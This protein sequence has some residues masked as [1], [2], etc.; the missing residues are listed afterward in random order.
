MVYKSLA[1]VAIIL[2]SVHATAGDVLHEEVTRWS[3]NWEWQDVG[4]TFQHTADLVAEGEIGYHM[5]GSGEDADIDIDLAVIITSSEAINP[6]YKTTFAWGIPMQTTVTQ[7]GSR[8]ECG[9]FEY[10]R[11]NLTPAE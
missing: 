1:S 6:S 9:A 11:G 7:E 5:H 8:Y 2:E 3:P 10:T 4:S